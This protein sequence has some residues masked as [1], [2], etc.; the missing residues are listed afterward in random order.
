[1]RDQDKQLEHD[2]EE[3]RRN[4]RLSV[5]IVT[6][7]PDGDELRKTLSSLAESAALLSGVDV[8]VYI[9][10]NSP[11]TTTTAD[12]RHSF[13]ALKV[14][15]LSG[16]GNIGFGRANNLI[17][18]KIGHYHLVLNPD[19]TMDRSALANALSFLRQHPDCGLLTPYAE[20]PSGA[21]QYL[22]K[23]FPSVVDLAIRGFAPQ[24]M[25]NRFRRRLD[26][27]EMRGETEDLTTWD[28]LIVSGCFMLFRKK[29]FDACS[30]FNPAYFLY[31]EDFD[32][33]LRAAKFCRIAYVPS[34][35]IV[36][37]GGKAARKGLWHITR[38]ITSASRFY[39]RWGLKIL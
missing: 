8:D 15:L 13:G 35:K 20:A 2:L 6:Y 21:R 30:G 22:C 10:D 29:V 24:A 34:V 25:Q 14:E 38:F 28:P 36:H 19:V 1:M 5:C 7:K 18:P 3:R 27:Y 31:F 9:V 12:V 37:G 33:S 11:D 39:R 23:R 32:L 17:A 4:D 26:R 16:H